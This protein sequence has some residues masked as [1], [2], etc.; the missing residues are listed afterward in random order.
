MATTTSNS[1]SS[2]Q[3]QLRP[4]VFSGP[5]GSGKSTLLKRLMA[6]FPTAFAFSVSHTTR[7]P[8]AGEKNGQDYHF[9]TREK[10][11][12]GIAN[13]EF[14]EHAEFSGNMYGTSKKAVEAVLSSGRICALDIDL[15]GVKNLKKTDLN[16]LYCFVKPPSIE[17][18]ETRL[19][20]RKTETEESLS[21]RLATARIDMEIAENESELFDHVVVND[22]LDHAYD[23]LK[24]IL[25]V[26]LEIINK[27]QQKQ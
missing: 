2:S 14:L 4:I 12:E 18:L 8:R 1:S 9:V 25:A 22:T 17:T 10:M 7:N 20:N 19:R 24:E 5:S 16:P 3:Q 21:K 11:K 26:Q 6:E 13:N 27:K 23:R 15:Q